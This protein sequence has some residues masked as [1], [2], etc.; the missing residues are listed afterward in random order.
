MFTPNH[1]LETDEAKIAAPD[2]QRIA[3]LMQ[4]NE[5]GS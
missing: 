2:A 4:D 5:A 3:E 1:F